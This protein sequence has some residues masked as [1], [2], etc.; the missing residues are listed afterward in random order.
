MSCSRRPTRRAGMTNTGSTVRARRVSRHSRMSIAAR[1]VTS[2]MTLLTTL[3]RV[4]VT[5]VWAPTTSLLSRD[6]IAPG[7]RPGEEGDR[8]PDHLG[9]QGGSQV[10]DQRLADVRTAPALQHVEPGVGDGGGDAEH[11]EPGDHRAVS[12]GDRRVDDLADDERRHEGDQ[13]GER[14]SRRRTARAAGDT[15]G[16]TSRSAAASAATG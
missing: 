9:E 16:R 10:E 13:G 8:H 6:V 3:P 4:L 7:R 14:R 11:G 1:A 5:A 15:A 12:V 2:P